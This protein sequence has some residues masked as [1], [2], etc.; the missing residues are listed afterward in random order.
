MLMHDYSRAISYYKTAISGVS[1]LD[2]HP[3]RLELASLLRQ[4]KRLPEC[5]AVIR[6]SLQL[7][8]G[9]IILIRTSGYHKK[10]NR[11]QAAAS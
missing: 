7:L 10:R 5:L 1:G 3:L 4:L 9:S 2:S 8:Q 11:A 6:E